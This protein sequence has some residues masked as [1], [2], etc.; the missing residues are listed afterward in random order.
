[1]VSE[2]INSPN[3]L[4]EGVNIKHIILLGR[5]QRNLLFYLYI[6]LFVVLLT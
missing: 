4:I 1:M 5:I 2:G 6:Q 3:V